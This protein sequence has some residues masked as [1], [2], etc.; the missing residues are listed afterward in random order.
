MKNTT[1]SYIIVLLLIAFGISRFLFID[2]MV[3]ASTSLMINVSFL[4]ILSLLTFILL[5]YPKDSKINN[6]M[7]VKV[8]LIVLLST[9]IIEFLLG[10]FLGFV[11]NGYSL[12]LFNIF[13]NSSVVMLACIPTEI[14][15]YILAK[16]SVY[17]KKP[18][19]FL[20]IGLIIVDILLSLPGI[21]NAETIFRYVCTTALPYI[22]AEFLC[23]YLSYNF[24]IASSLIY[25]IFT[26]I[27]IYF[28][29]IV[30][31]LGDFIKSAILLLMPFIIYL[32]TSKIVLYYSKDKKAD[33]NYKLKLLIYIPILFF[34]SAMIILITGVFKYKLI[35]V[36]SNSMYPVISRGDAVLYKKTKDIKI[37]DVITFKMS[38]RVITHRVVS[39]KKVNGHLSIKTK[40]DNNNAVDSFFVKESDVL[41]VVVASIDKIGYPTVWFNEE[42]MGG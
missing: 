30:P 10:L 4:M 12:T 34:L 35:A 27:Y 28:V 32:Y 1:K 36:A 11:S 26:N 13:R 6:K 39:I 20:T 38:G 21:Y 18:I 22:A 2:K 19:V 5:K 3:N 40:G 31:N 37:N 16:N 33:L 9:L 41:G 14:I 29:P 23:S 25:M 8:V 17:N 24:G 42:I 15:R 7:S